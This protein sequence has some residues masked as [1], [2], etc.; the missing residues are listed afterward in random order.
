MQMIS[1]F[2]R[3]LDRAEQA[4]GQGDI[5]ACLRSLRVLPLADFGSLMFGLAG[6]AYPALARLLPKMADHE[7]QRGWTGTSGVEN[8]K[9]T[10]NFVQTMS[11]GFQAL[12][13]GTP[14]NRRILDFGCGY[15]R[16]IRLM[17]H[18]SDPDQVYGC[19]PWDQSIAICRADRLLGQLARSEYLPKALPFG[20]TKFDLVYANSVFTHTSPRA[21]A[22]ALR[23]IRASIA[24]N[25]VLL[26]TLRPVEFWAD[27]ARNSPKIDPDKH[28]AEHRDRGYSFHPHTRAPV[29]GD[30]TYGDASYSLEYLETEFPE[31]RLAR[32]DR[33]LDSPFQIL[34]FL[35]PR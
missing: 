2:R 4:A 29:D 16:M 10:V 6:A 13:G 12:T 21:T 9:A 5:E 3:H 34:A 15:G 19:D 22:A 23:A 18:F 20:E 30:V 14:R 26:I 17:Y 8:L 25:G 33:T 28:A 7:V 35:R 11:F 27:Y 32:L 24:E 1:V 31:W